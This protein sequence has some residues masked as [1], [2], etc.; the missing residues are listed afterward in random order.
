MDDGRG[1]EQRRRGP[2][3]LGKDL[4]FLSIITSSH[5]AS[6]GYRNPIVR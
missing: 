5:L 6:P 4:D 2:H 1:K 3:E